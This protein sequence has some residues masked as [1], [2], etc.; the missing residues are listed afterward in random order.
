MPTKF[1]LGTCIDYGS[2]PFHDT[3][4]S[5]PSATDHLDDVNRTLTTST[6]SSVINSATNYASANPIL[7]TLVFD[8]N[9]SSLPLIYN[10]SMT[11]FLK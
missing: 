11:H 4:N 8:K 9:Y 3:L 1:F 7:S 6:A 2:T 5:F 10:G